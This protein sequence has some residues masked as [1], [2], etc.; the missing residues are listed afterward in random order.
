M[1]AL[2]GES[3]GG[4][5][6]LATGDVMGFWLRAWNGIRSLVQVN[7]FATR[8]LRARRWWAIA[9]TVFF[10]ALGVFL[11]ASDYSTGAWLAFAAGV[12]SLLREAWPAM[13]DLFGTPTALIEQD[14]AFVDELVAQVR[15]SVEE[16][17]DGFAVARV[18]H[19]A[20]EAVLRSDRL[21][22]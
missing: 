10:F 6:S 16:E 7:A 17:R 1:R 3:G 20:R 2:D 11:A 13:A 4:N 14:D 18:P 12:I 21:D 8:V 19:H 15:P 5:E 9:F 22:R